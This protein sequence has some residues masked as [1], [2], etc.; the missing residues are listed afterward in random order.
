[1]LPQ[2]DIIKASRLMHYFLRYRDP[3]GIYLFKVN[4]GKTKTICKTYSKLLIK[5]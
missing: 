3:P 5:T 4:S 2:N 1:M